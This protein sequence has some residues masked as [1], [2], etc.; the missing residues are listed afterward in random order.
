M[1]GETEIFK[2]S[3]KLTDAKFWSDE[4]PESLRRLFHS[5]R[6]RQ[7]GGRAENQH[8]FSQDGIQG[9]RRHRRRL[10]QRQICL[11]HRLRAAFVATIGPAWARRIPTGCTI[12]TRELVRSTHANYIRWM[13]ISPQ[14]VD[15][16]AC[17]QAHMAVAEPVLAEGEDVAGDG[18]LG[19]VAPAA[20]GDPLEHRPQRPAASGNLLGG[21]GQRPAQRG[22]ALVG[23]VPQACLPSELRTLGVRP[24]QAHRCRAVGKRV[25]SPT[26]A[27]ISTAVERPT[28][29]IW[30]STG[31]R[32][33]VLARAS[34]SRVVA[35][36]S[37]SK[38][39]ISD[40]MSSRRR[41]PPWGSSRP[42]R[43]SRPAWPNKLVCS[44][45]MPWRARLSHP[46]SRSSMATVAPR[47]I[48][49][50]SPAPT[51]TP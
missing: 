45:R 12:T 28:P 32:S 49:S 23:D 8:R 27:M 30:Q 47:I 15:V 26:S 20:L 19:D 10:S 3:G 5:H 4:T 33:S 43:N 42:A 2:A 11:A 41:E 37:R 14:A 36:I 1:S 6:E 13:H 38:S 35:V 48:A 40:S 51:S 39:P 17:D 9:R 46:L 22:G 18:D 7:G 16:R 25:T 31:T 21:L 50:S 34:I 24:A 29:R 44:G